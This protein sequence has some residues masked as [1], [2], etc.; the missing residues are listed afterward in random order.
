MSTRRCSRAHG[1]VVTFRVRASGR[2]MVLGRAGLAF[3]IFFPRSENN[4][5]AGF[6]GF[7]VGRFS[8][9][10]PEQENYRRSALEKSG[11]KQI[12]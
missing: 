8:C 3:K 10:S 5:E 2:L 4:F 6:S 1:G 11:F 12:S 7:K 9:A